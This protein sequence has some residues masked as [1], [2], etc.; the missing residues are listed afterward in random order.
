MTEIERE[1]HRDIDRKRDTDIFHLLVHSPNSCNS[2]GWARPKPGDK[3]C[4]WVSH[5]GDRNPSIWTIRCLLGCALAKSCIGS[6]LGI[7]S[8]A[9]WF[10]KQVHQMMGDVGT[11][12]GMLTSRSYTLTPHQH[13]KFSVSSHF[14]LS[15]DLQIPSHSFC[16]FPAHFKSKPQF[17]RSLLPDKTDLRRVLYFTS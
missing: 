12:T 14:Y 8:W 13:F 9:F 10:G 1:I 16:P 6:R 15:K 17:I 2:P 4:T 7:R 11:P 5:V 3:S